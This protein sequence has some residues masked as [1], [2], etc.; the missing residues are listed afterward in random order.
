MVRYLQAAACLL[1]TTV[2]S[3]VNAH[4]DTDSWS[5]IDISIP[6]PLSDHS[7]ATMMNDDARIIVLTG[8]CDSPNGNEFVVADWGEGFDCTSITAK[9]YAFTPTRESSSG[10]WTGSF[11]TLPDMPR[12]R[13]RHA[14][15]VVNGILCVVGGRNGTDALIAEVDCYNPTSN[16]WTTPT[17][18]P[19]DRMVSDLAAFAHP[20]N[21]GEIYLVGGYNGPYFAS[22]NVTVVK[23]STGSTLDDLVVTY[24]DGPRLN[25]K[26]GDVDTAIVD[27][28]VYVSGGYT[29]EDSFA[30]AK[31]S[32]ER[33]DL[34]TLPGS[35]ATTWSDVDS[36]NYER[37]DKQLVGINGRV[38]ALGGETKVDLYGIAEAELPELWGRSEVL[39]TV[40][41]FN[42]SEDEN[43]GLAEWR[44]LSSMP[45]QI[46]RFAAIEWPVEDS[47]GYIFVFGGQAGYDADCKCFRTTDKVMVLDIDHA[48]LEMET[49]GASS[50][51]VATIVHA[52]RGLSQ[53]ATVVALWLVL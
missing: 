49:D 1:T 23:Y 45:A 17:S 13:Y 47:D 4:D 6:T 37:G 26:R 36:L 24:A 16:V 43:G 11:K 46:F 38:Y 20:T 14:S 40:E 9:A 8:G 3:K 32:V 33:L 31:N 18:L 21:E 52:V 34:S 28:Y 44:E 10:A 30:M 42:P 53:V 22:E 48:E 35:S 29:H 41:V 27:G 7:V 39:D 50:S 12:P 5:Y 51:S 25:G 19:S 2:L 15:A